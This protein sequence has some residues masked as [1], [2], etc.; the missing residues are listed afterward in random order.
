MHKHTHTKKKKSAQ[1]GLRR[2]RPPGIPY[3]ARH[4]AERS[5]LCSPSTQPQPRRAGRRGTR[6]PVWGVRLG[7]AGCS[8]Q[9]VNMLQNNKK[10]KKSYWH[11]MAEWPHGETRLFVGG[12]PPCPVAGYIRP[13]SP[14]EKGLPILL[15]ARLPASQGQR[16]PERYLVSESFSCHW[17]LSIITCNAALVIVFSHGVQG[18]GAYS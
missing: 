5:L 8:R 14:A 1:T 6:A 9:S 2:T 16:V 11:G 18:Q 7:W 12:P 15:P 17:V 4:A 3:A 13:G 10:K